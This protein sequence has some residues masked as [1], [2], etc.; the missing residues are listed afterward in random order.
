MY[1]DGGDTSDASYWFSERLVRNT[2]HDRISNMHRSLLYLGSV[3]KQEYNDKLDKAKLL[4]QE[5]ATLM[6]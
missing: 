3:K 1:L 4:V 5:T 6:T 2:I